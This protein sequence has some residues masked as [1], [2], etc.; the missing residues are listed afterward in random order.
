MEKKLGKNGGWKLIEIESLKV[1]QNWKIGQN[2]NIDEVDNR[3][4]IENEKR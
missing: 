2:W 4:K 1:E 3:T